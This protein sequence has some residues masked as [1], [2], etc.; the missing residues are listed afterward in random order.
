MGPMQR[1]GRG[2]LGL[3]SR[4]HGSGLTA[5]GGCS[6]G[7]AG[8]GDQRMA[9]TCRSGSRMRTQRRDELRTV[10]P[11]YPFRAARVQAVE[12]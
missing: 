8:G 7:E 5:R 3:R 1:S 6:I 12:R 2:R 9:D 11:R 4:A 10:A